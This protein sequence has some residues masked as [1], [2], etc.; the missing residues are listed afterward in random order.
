M[1]AGSA[2][3]GTAKSRGSFV[4]VLERYVLERRHT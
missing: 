4:R 3:G 2:G 1:A